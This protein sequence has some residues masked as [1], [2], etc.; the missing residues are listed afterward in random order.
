MSAVTRLEAVVRGRV[1][2]VGYRYFVL[3]RAL[4]LG[5]HPLETKPDVCWQLPIRR[6]FREVDDAPLDEWPPVV[7]AHGHRPA[8]VHAGHLHDGAER[9]G[10]VGGGHLV[11]IEDLAAGRRQSI[12]IEE[13]E[14]GMEKIIL[15]NKKMICYFIADQKSDYYQSPIFSKV[16][17][18][19]QHHPDK[20]RMKEKQDKLSLSFDHI[21]TISAAKTI[22]EEIAVDL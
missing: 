10:L 21:K 19:L 20:C 5:L 17:H 22:L 1:Q 6:T 4:D 14:L 13:D 2:G 3:D 11:G 15:K 16:L 12:W 7:D 9:E 8:V 18:Y